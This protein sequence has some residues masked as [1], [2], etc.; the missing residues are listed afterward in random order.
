MPELIETLIEKKYTVKT[1]PLME[2][3][4]DIGQHKDYKQAQI[5]ALD[6]MK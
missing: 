3:W 6:F 1:F 5:D 2:F 4:L